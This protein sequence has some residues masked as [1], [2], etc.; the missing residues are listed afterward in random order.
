MNVLC[1]FS[2]ESTSANLPYSVVSVLQ[3]RIANFAIL[4]LCP[5]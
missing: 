4:I 2:I 5:V 3:P 1:T